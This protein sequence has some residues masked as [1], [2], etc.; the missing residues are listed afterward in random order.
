ARGLGA[1][2]SCGCLKV[3]RLCCSCGPLEGPK[4]RVGFFTCGG[5]KLKALGGCGEGKARGLGACPS[6]GC[7][8]VGRLCCSCGPLEGPKVRV[9]FFTCGGGKL[10][11]LG[12]CGELKARGLAACPS[13]G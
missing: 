2:P 7:L 1:C 9:G 5:G 6:C 3:G 13:C 12:V 8:K 4:V 11:A 10:K